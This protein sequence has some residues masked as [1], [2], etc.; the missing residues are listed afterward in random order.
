MPSLRRRSCKFT[1]IFLLSEFTP[2]RTCIK[3]TITATAS[4]VKESV[5]T[6]LSGAIDYAG[7]F[8]PAGLPMS[9]AVINYAMYRNSNYHWMLG[10]FVL[11]VAQLDDFIENAGDFISRDPTRP[12][13]LS[14]LAGEDLNDTFRRIV[15]FNSTYGPN[16]TVDSLEISC[17][18]PFEDREY[19]QRLTGRCDCLF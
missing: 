13:R 8:P 18:Q 11:S 4:T 17:Q 9:E 6:L 3:W 19:R 10:R 16:V 5:R 15:D 12:W 1:P 14:V 2:S 7:L